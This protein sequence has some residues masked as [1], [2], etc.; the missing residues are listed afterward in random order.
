MIMIGLVREE[1]PHD[2]STTFSRLTEFYETVIN[3]KNSRNTR[4]SEIKMDV[5]K[6]SAVKNLYYIT[7][8]TK[9]ENEIVY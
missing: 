6:E 5:L 2:S 4:N 1:G 8:C 7:L 3:E 9:L